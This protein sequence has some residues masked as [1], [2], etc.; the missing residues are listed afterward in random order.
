MLG[1]L[2]PLGTGGTIR[3]EKE[4]ILIGN[5]RLCDAVIQS[6]HVAPVHCQLLFRDAGWY[7]RDLSGAVGTKVNALPV[8][9]SRLHHGDIVWIGDRHYELF[10]DAEGFGTG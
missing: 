2:R 8:T 3:L 1:E 6:R 10:C 4:R 5:H 9:E 7:V